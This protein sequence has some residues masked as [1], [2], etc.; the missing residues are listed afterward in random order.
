MIYLLLKNILY[1]LQLPKSYCI[2]LR[3]NKLC[4]VNNYSTLVKY[5]VKIFSYGMPILID[6]SLLCTMNGKF[7]DA[8]IQVCWAQR[9]SQLWDS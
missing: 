2:V 4:R 5:N 6:V 9:D 3:I 7:C 1:V 8:C